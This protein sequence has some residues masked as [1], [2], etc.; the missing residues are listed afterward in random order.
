MKTVKF[1]NEIYT[2]EEEFHDSYLL[3]CGLWV[4]KDLCKEISDVPIVLTVI[5]RTILV[6]I[7]ILLFTL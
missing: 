7:L 3:S 5:A 2:V 6:L 4:K 1:E